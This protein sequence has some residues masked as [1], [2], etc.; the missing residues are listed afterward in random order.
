VKPFLIRFGTALGLSA[1]AALACALPAALRVS[2]SGVAMGTTTGRIWIA[3]AAAD[4]LP[5]LMAVLVLRGARE[6]LRALAG[7]GAGLRAWGL[8]LWGALQFAILT[9]V[10]AV[11]RATTHQHALAAVTYAFAALAVAIASA[12]VCA[13][14]VAVVAAASPRTRRVLLVALSCLALIAVAAIGMRFLRA[15]WRE[16][17]PSPAAATVIDVLAFGLAALFGSRPSFALRGPIGVFGVPAAIVVFLVG[18]PVLRDPAL[19]R[20][21][22]DRAPLI[23]PIVEVPG[24]SP[25]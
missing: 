20:A 24:A 5:M 16:P 25:Q 8:A 4:L 6:G 17:T 15:V 7:E 1:A 3:L 13:R 23:A 18:L 21:V 11:L 14:I 9:V 19:R 12:L 2:A 22:H 10:G